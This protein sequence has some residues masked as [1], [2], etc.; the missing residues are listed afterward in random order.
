M[1]TE[2]GDSHEIDEAS[3]TARSAPDDAPADASSALPKG[4]APDFEDEATVISTGAPLTPQ[5]LPA[6]LPP[7][8]LGQALVGQRLNSL[9]LEEFIGSGGMGAVFRAIDTEL[10]RTVA[11]KVLSTHD[12]DDVETPRR[13]KIE[14]QSAARLDHPHI[15][16][17]YNVGEDRGAAYIVFEYIQGPNIRDVV[18]THGPL[19]LAD[20]LDFTLQIADALAHAWQR[21]VV[22][23]DIKPSNILV[24]PDRQ[25]KLVDMGLARLRWIEE[26]QDLTESGMTLGT[27]DYI[28]PEQARNPKNADTRSDIY[29]LGCT[30]FFM[31]TGRPPFPGGTA[32]QKLLSHQGD[33]PPDI[34]QFRADVPESVVNLVG[35]MLAKKVQDR[36]QNPAELVGA[37]LAITDELG[38]PHAQVQARPWPRRAPRGGRLRWHL[39]W[40]IPVALLIGAIFGIQQ[41]FRAARQPTVFPEV[42]PPN[43]A[44]D[45]ETF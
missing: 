5:T 34:G 24:N 11:V 28:S 44:S 16:R 36:F 21:Q 20:A 15:A 38:V 1:D 37:L 18:N 32:L 10:N 13:F 8:E 19:P 25:V 41:L 43:A 42:Q 33:A 39:P 35:T 31:L 30:L 9:L 22:H 2:P 3:D 6:Q 40:L 4:P 17:V 14:A 23:R 12:G 29:S 7:R 27:F 45:S 26:E